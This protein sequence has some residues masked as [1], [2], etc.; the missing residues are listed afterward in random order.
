[1]WSHFGGW[2][3][4]FLWWRQSMEKYRKKTY[5]VTKWRHII[6]FPSNLLKIFVWSI[7]NSCLNLKSIE[8]FLGMFWAYLWSWSPYRD[9][10]IFSTLSLTKVAKLL[11]NLCKWANFFQ[12]TCK[13][14]QYEKSKNPIFRNLQKPPVGVILIPS[15]LSRVNWIK[16]I[17]ET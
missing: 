15:S 3:H 1:M 7:S 14:K 16:I 4:H 17:H 2:R 13:I 11:F 6:W 9:S 10:Y 8:Q 12:K 5:D